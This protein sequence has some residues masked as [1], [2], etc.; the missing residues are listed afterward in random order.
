MKQR[1]NLSVLML[2]LFTIF[3]T[4][5]I[6]NKNPFDGYDGEKEGK[7]PCPG[8]ENVAF[9]P[10][11]Q[12]AWH[13]S[14]KF[15]G[16]NYI[17]VDSISYPDG[18]NCPGY[19]HI[20]F[21]SVGF[22]LINSNGTNKR[23]IFPYQLEL[24]VWSPD[25]EWLAFVYGDQIYKM[26]FNGTS[27]DETT[28]TQLTFEGRNYLPSWSPDGQR[29]AF[30][31]NRQSEGFRIWIMN[32]SG[33]NKRLLVGGRGPDWIN[34]NYILFEGFHSEIYKINIQDTSNAKKLT[35]F[36]DRNIYASLNRF[37]KYNKARNLIAF[38]H[39]SAELGA[40]IWLMDTTG[41]NL[42]QITRDGVNYPFSWSP[43]GQKIVYVK[44]NPRDWSY[45]NGT[46]WILNLNTM[47]EKQLT[48]NIPKSD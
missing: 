9:D 21:D 15:I 3:I 19:Y 41:S 47:E 29:I 7:H 26:K 8:I 35:N 39:T 44:Y 43:D 5:C 33:K 27:F 13:P 20:N 22:W 2:F 23:R 25:G 45:K 32:L 10:Y 11:R 12:P 14:G 36:N 18:E 40:N 1:F 31:S 16:F 17:P 37:P 4:A 48:F 28:L 38:V 24:P 34:L 30:D 46:L 42:T 6:R